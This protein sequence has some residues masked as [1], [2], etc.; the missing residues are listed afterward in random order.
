MEQSN[1]LIDAIRHRRSL[2]IFDS[3]PVEKEKIRSCLE[4]ASLAP[5]ADN[6]QPWRFIILT[7]DAVKKDFVKQ[8]FSGIYRVTRWA[9]KAPV[10]VVL[11]AEKHFVVHRAGKWMQTVP[12]HFIDIGIAGE[13]FVLQAQR[14]GLGS[15][16]IGWFDVK[17]AQKFFRLPKNVKVVELM[18]V[19]YPP[20]GWQPRP[21]KRKK[22][23][24]IA[25][26]NGWGQP[27]SY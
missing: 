6:I 8:V 21:R 16:W 27:F 13:H 23:D 9:V 14:L 11:L 15:C 2:R 20:P 25:F 7:D 1:G 18:A 22:V 26:G 19:G 12:Y 17:K 10:L 24:E 4:A 3:R 5:S